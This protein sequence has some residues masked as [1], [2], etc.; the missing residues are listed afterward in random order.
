ML[1]SILY[2]NC[3]TNLGIT[4]L[5]EVMETLNEVHFGAAKWNVLGLSLGIYQT[6][7]DVVKD[8]RG[9]SKLYLRKT[10]ELWLQCQDKVKKK[11]GATWENLIKAVESTGDNAAANRLRQK[12]NLIS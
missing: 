8:E 3:H 9:N 11:G 2:N 12:L 1:L 4:D 6:N 7:L 5:D 10:I